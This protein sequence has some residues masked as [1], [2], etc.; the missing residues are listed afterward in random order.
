MKHTNKENTE[1]FVNAV[2]TLANSSKTLIQVNHDIDKAATERL[3]DPSFDLEAGWQEDFERLA[4]II[5]TGCMVAEQRIQGI[6]RREA[7]RARLEANPEKDQETQRALQYLDMAPEKSNEASGHAEMQDALAATV[8]GV[9]KIM[10]GISE[11]ESTV[12]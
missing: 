3:K 9:Q 12:G 11:K 4:R 5:D 8:K 2:H 1:A 7:K 10:R 6:G